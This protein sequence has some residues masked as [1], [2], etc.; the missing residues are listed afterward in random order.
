MVTFFIR[1]LIRSWTLIFSTPT[2]D[3]ENRTCPH[4]SPKLS[5]VAQCPSQSLRSTRT[6]LSQTGASFCLTFA[7]ARLL[8]TQCAWISLRSDTHSRFCV[9]IHVKFLLQNKNRRRWQ[10]FL[11]IDPAPIRGTQ[12]DR[13]TKINEQNKFRLSLRSNQKKSGSERFLIRLSIESGFQ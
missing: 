13:G 1:T 3:G 12:S 10:R 9:P 2:G 6:C 11:L 7:V 8:R 4:P 5:D